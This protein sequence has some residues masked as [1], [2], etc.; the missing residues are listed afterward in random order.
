MESW[1]GNLTTLKLLPPG[2]FLPT[3]T[4]RRAALSGRFTTR[5]K[6]SKSATLPGSS[7]RSE[8][9]IPEWQFSAP[10][11]PARPLL[12]CTR[13]P[14]KSCPGRPPI[15]SAGLA[16]LSYRRGVEPF[17]DAMVIFVVLAIG[18]LWFL[19]RT[20]RRPPARSRRWAIINRRSRARCRGRLPSRP[21]GYAGARTGPSG[22]RLPPP[23]SGPHAPGPP[24]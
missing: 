8:D 10:W 13:W 2:P 23:C 24:R 12:A 18:W 4:P 11:G 21:S 20:I 19:R 9:S 3:K 16:Y 15:P 5:S 17:P 14:S 6:P 22:D 1:G 7:S